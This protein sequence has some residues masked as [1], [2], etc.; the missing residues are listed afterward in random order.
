MRRHTIRNAPARFRKVGDLWEGLRTSKP[1]DLE[2][3]LQ[4]YAKRHK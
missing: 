4:R 2:A 1:V 3:V